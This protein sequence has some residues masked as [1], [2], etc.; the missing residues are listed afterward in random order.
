MPDWPHQI[1]GVADTIARIEAGVKSLC[2]SSPTGGGKSLMM[3]RLIEWAVERG[4]SVAVF[5]NRRLLTNQLAQGLN[6]DGIHL[7]V[8]AADFESWTDLNAPVQICSTPTEASRVLR[9]RERGN[10][11]A[12]L[13]PAQLVFGDEVHLNKADSMSAIVKEYHEKHDAV[14]VGVSATP[15]GVSHL[16]S[17][18]I[19]A[20]NTSSLRE[21][22]ALV[23]AK[24]FE[25]AV[26]DLPKIRKSKTGIFSQSEMDEA[27]KAIWSQ[28]VVGHIWGNW[29]KMRPD[30]KS[31]IGFAPGVKESHGL[32]Q[33]FWKHG[34]NAA[35]ISSD[36][37]F[38]DGNEYRTNAQEDR[39]EIFARSKD[40]SVPMIWNRFVLREA[41]DLPWL[42]ML[43][44]ATPI[45]SLLSYIQT[46][47]RVLR[48]SPSTYKEF[49]LIVDHA[50]TLR[51]HGSPN[52]DRDDDWRRYFYA[53]D[54]QIT[55]DRV[56]RLRDP[57]DKEAEPITCPQCG[58]IRNSGGLCKGCGFE[59][60][61]SV[62]KVI[63]ED[64]SLRRVKDQVFPK[65]HTKM[66]SDTATQW[67]SCYYRAKHAKKPMSFKQ[68]RALFKYENRYWPPMDL[69]LM[70]KSKADWSRKVV[71]V[72]VTDL[73]PRT[74][75]N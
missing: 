6:R 13:F 49:A 37:I 59:S 39:D 35:H 41:I 2:L 17:E 64:G 48:A 21:C 19:V 7:G 52:M 68:A 62:R 30:G 5:T 33:E 36:F 40:G 1:S 66:K 72:G 34:I 46:V 71:N 29:K 31:C 15:L 38:V 23:I 57:D 20:G 14:F 8:R 60:S 25:P 11:G 58:L 44:L 56:D 26:V 4:Q 9:A 63:Q 18:L 24:S 74:T 65:R 45:A 12:S 53:P 67:E 61:T 51:M 22:G 70:P 47:G 54:G 16:C 73:I 42:E 55:K 3:L 32:A 10:D 27:V 50:G 28:H 43:T 69:P 75:S